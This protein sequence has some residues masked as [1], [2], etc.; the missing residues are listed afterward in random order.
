MIKRR[1]ASFTG[2]GAYGGEWMALCVGFLMRL[3]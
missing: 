1:A 2:V 3:I